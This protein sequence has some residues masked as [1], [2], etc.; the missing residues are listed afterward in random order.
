MVKLYALGLSALIAARV[1]AQPL[2]TNGTPVLAHTANSGGCMGV[3]DMDGDGLD[4]V[5]QLDDSKHVHILYQE[6]DG[7]FTHVDY[8]SVSF[9]SQWGWAIADLGNDG[10]KDVVSG[11]N[12]DGTHREMGHGAG[13]CML[14]NPSYDFNDDLIPLGGTAWV[15]LA[16]QWLNNPRP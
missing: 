13:P 2:F 15:R 16:E 12:G 9:S 5:V 10:H 7:S 6:A 14:H 3:T 1:S 8:G 4:D 11:G